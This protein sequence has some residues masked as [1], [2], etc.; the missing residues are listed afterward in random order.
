V[1]SLSPKQILVNYIDNLDVKRY[2]NLRSGNALPDEEDILSLHIALSF[3]FTEDGI[4]S[5]YYGTEQ[6]FFGGLNPMNREAMWNTRYYGPNAKLLPPYNT[7]NI[8]FKYIAALIKMRMDY[9]A[10]RRGSMSVKWASTE[11]NHG[12]GDDAGVIAFERAY[13]DQKLLIVMN[14]HLNEEKSTKSG[15]VEM[16]TSFENG[17]ILEDIVPNYSDIRF[18][19]R[20]G[21]GSFVDYSGDEKISE[22]VVVG[23]NGEIDIRVKPL[24]FKVFK[25][26]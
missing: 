5:I 24:S 21:S 8:T 2:L 9:P 11:G 26:K 23:D 3:Q 7:E 20:N 6:Q 16:D 1:I 22:N 12:A 25:K 4:P 15:G 19:K 18:K 13:G 10:L 17:D 14:T